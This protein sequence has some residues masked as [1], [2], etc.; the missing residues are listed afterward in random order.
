[1]YMHTAIILEPRKHKALRF[2]IK[3]ALENLSDEWNIIVFH[4]N[5]NSEYVHTIV[6]KTLSQ[7]KSR[8][9]LINLNVDNLS[10]EEY[11]NLLISNKNFYNNI[12]S[13]IFLIFQTDSMIFSR[14][15]N[16]I[17]DFLKYDYVGAP[18]PHEPRDN[19]HKVG[20]GGFSLRK[21]SKMLEIMDKESNIG[22]P[23]DVFFSCTTTVPLYKPS[24][25]EAKLFAVEHIFSEKTFACHQPWHLKNE[26]IKY[27]PE[28]RRLIWLNDKLPPR[29]PILY[30]KPIPFYNRRSLS[31]MQ[32]RYNI[33]NRRIARFIPR[34]PYQRILR[35]LQIRTPNIGLYVRLFK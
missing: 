30:R 3:N 4:G 7:Y 28:I 10:R 23:E 17:N 5:K 12:P 31:I 25:D 16:L 15:K 22:L 2:V 13:E 14:N 9:S 33:V 11:S 29:R 21:K 26:L 20:N 27:Y 6:H 24:V 32:S 35:S 8:I 1:M 34:R 18:W 19:G